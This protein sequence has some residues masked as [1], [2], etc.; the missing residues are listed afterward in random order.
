MTSKTYQD[1][2]RPLQL[3]AETAMLPMVW[4]LFSGTQRPR[5]S[6]VMLNSM[7]PCRHV[8]RRAVTA[9]VLVVPVHRRLLIKRPR[10]F[11]VI[12]VIRPDTDTELR[13]HFQKTF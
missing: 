12:V 9:M 5:V 13:L 6:Y 10:H 3:S 11:H 2:V 7:L 8:H 4:V 1:R